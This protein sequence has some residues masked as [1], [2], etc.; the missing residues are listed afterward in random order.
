VADPRD[1]A[2]R[3][4]SHAWQAAW[5]HVRDRLDAVGG[6]PG[7]ALD[8]RHARQVAR[9][10]GRARRAQLQAQRAHAAAVARRE[11]LLR[12]AKRGLPTGL[13]LAAGSAALTVPSPDGADGAL[14]SLAV[15]GVLQ[16]TLAG[17]R[18]LR[19]PPL[20]VPPAVLEQGPPPAPH[21]RSAAAPAVRRLDQAGGALRHLLPLVAP[22]GRPV[23][24][25][26]WHAAGDADTALRWQAARLAAAEPYRELDA[27][28]LERLEDGVQAQERLV[29]AVADLV[30]ASADPLGR[31][32]LQ[33]VT[34][35][36]CGLAAGLREVP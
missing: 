27:Q 30:T 6:T 5:P 25:E 19:P 2:R 33:D 28:L 8:R 12:R 24:E 29:Q 9:D 21:P 4:A 35:R 26:A 11:R 10:H 18:L 1:R 22:V 3:L 17:T 13:L 23:A 20:P 36:L 14:L 16:A 34:D 15:V 31:E 32:R 7:T